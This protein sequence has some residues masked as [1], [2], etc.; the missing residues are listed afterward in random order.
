MP[1][2]TGSLPVSLPLLIRSYLILETETG[3]SSVVF[4]CFKEPFGV[5]FINAGSKGLLY[6]TGLSLDLQQKLKTVLC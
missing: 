3:H 2:F 4:L 5:Y 1:A 6:Y